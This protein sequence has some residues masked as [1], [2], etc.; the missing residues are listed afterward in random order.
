MST[1]RKPAYARM[2]PELLRG[3][4]REA[5][6]DIAVRGLSL[7]SRCI[8]PGGLF[9]ARCGT[10]EHGLRYVAEAIQKGAAA[11]AYEPADGIAAPGLANGIPLIPV[12]RL[13]HRAGTIAA[14]FY[15]DPS[16][17]LAVTGVTGTNGKTS[18][19]MI[20]AQV[21]SDWDRPTGVI[22]TLGYGVFG[23]LTPGVETTPDAVRLQSVLAD[24]RDQGSRDA[25]M[26]VSS[27]AIDQGR[28]E[29]VHFETTVF[30]NL[31][32]DHLDYHGDMEA[33]RAAKGRLF[34][35]P[36]LRRVVLNLDD[37]AAEYFA[38][39][40]HPE[41]QQVGYGF[42]ASPPGWFHG[43]R[44]FSRP[45]HGECVLDLGIEGDFG[46]GRLRSRL[47]GHF[48]ALNLLAVVAGL[49]ARGFDF[50]QTLARVG[51]AQTIPGRMEKFGGGMH[52]LV[53]VD[54][55][56]TPD[57]LAQALDALRRHTRRR[58]IVVFGCGGDRD[59]GK[60]GQ[61]GRVAAGRADAI[62]LTDDNPRSEDP[63]SIL[64]DIRAGIPAG[65]AFDVERDRARAIARAYAG[66]DAGDVVLVAGKGHEAVQ[67]IGNECHHYS[68]R[69]V[70]RRL[71]AGVQ[72]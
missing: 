9:L 68:D 12:A 19:T 3:L 11:V 16:A 49:A 4:T 42:G 43:P 10:R 61:M 45:L 69:D 15:A 36:G 44:V 25:A 40:A 24:F 55:A 26:E 33:Y 21:L 67:I 30:T 23:K 31:T 47:F 71:V 72:A 46:A 52:P 53:V 34:E 20:L 58:L 57:A 28:V 60:R 17:D 66:A 13:G 7:D 29:G 35:W 27:H 41:V 54:Y 38:A 14:R 48:N 62:I 2:L 50:Q 70:V 59:R 32:R 56:H 18:V 39:R 37:P 65:S 5:V 51:Q 6:P 64:A 8:P 1:M 22:G 63:E